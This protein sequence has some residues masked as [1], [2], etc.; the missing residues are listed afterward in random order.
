MRNGK[1]GLIERR[2]SKDL[3][4]CLCSDR[5]GLICRKGCC[6]VG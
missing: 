2:L 4:K 1:E 6:G 5:G 3:D